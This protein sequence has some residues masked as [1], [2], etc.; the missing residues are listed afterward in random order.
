MVDS[1]I[2]SVDRD[3]FLK[4]FKAYHREIVRI[5]AEKLSESS[6]EH[7]IQELMAQPI[8]ELG[9]KLD[10]NKG[11]NY[12]LIVKNSSDALV[13][14]LECKK[15]KTSEMVSLAD[16]NKKALQQLI[17]YYLNEIIKDKKTTPRFSE[18]CPLN[19]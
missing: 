5:K 6:V 1:A 2:E 9:G 16:L 13:T 14:L 15:V 12:D 11:D 4:R 8:K 17:Y 18:V 7:A 19:R 10:L 3:A